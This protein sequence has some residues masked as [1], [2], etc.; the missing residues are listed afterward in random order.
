MCVHGLGHAHVFELL[1]HSTD[2]LLAMHDRL[3][4]LAGCPTPSFTCLPG[5]RRTE[6]NLSAG[7]LYAV[8]SLELCLLI[9]E[10]RVAPVRLLE[11]VHKSRAFTSL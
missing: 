10:H 3:A 2:T 11:H 9:A 6:M 5:V 7:A 8:G 4:R 1:V